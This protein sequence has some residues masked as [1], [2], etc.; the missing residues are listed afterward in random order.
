MLLSL[1]PKT[2]YTDQPEPEQTA[3]PAPLRRFAM[4]PQRLVSMLF[5]CF[6][7]ALAQAE[8]Y[9]WKDASGK[10]HYGDKP[11]A[12]QQSGSRQL[13]AP[14]P[15]ENPQGAR[16]AFL[17]SQRVEREKQQAEEDKKKAEADKSPPP[18]PPGTPPPPPAK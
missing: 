3:G 7:P 12:A 1:Y 15:P 4:R 13:T 16:K 18:P 9:S 5:A 17:E 6:L 10:T 8:L 14:P 2:Y 11:P